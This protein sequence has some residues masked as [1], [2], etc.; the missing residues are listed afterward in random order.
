[1]CVRRPS[2]RHIMC[3]KASRGLVMCVYVAGMHSHRAM[4]S[5]TLCFGYL[6]DSLRQAKC[7]R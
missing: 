3:A 5:D 7:P 2:N 6:W 1:M 4:Y